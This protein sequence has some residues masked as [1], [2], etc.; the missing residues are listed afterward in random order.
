VAWLKPEELPA[1]DWVEADHTVVA[2]YR[3]GIGGTDAPA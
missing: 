1:L 3:Q 2:A